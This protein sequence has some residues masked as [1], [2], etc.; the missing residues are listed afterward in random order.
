MERRTPVP[1]N[2]VSRNT[3]PADLQK[4]KIQQRKSERMEQ[5]DT[6]FKK[7]VAIRFGSEESE[8]EAPKKSL[9][10]DEEITDQQELAPTQPIDD[11]SDS[12]MSEE[13]D[14]ADLRSHL[15]E[16]FQQHGV[17]VVSGWFK[18]ELIDAKKAAKKAAKEQP[19]LKKQKK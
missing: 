3:H 8:E 13:D 7:R 15:S 18:L 10:F 19:P 2:S 14:E 17:D 11:D 16:A 12:S 5:D 4:S 1:R 9:P 6:P